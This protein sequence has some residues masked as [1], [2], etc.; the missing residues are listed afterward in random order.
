[1]AA[2]GK[3]LARVW[4]HG[5]RV[6]REGRPLKETGEVT[7]RELLEQGYKGEE[8][9]FFL[10]STH[11][12]KPLALGD[13]SLKAAAKARAR[14]DHFLTRLGAVAT[15]DDAGLRTVEERLF[16]LK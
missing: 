16:Q 9:R 12:R 1:A 8:V 10:L 4:L 7:V 3:P 2:T 14:L 5:E 6:L 15:G 13:D 11:Y